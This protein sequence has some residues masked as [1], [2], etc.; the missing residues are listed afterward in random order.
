M[1]TA[2]L[3]QPSILRVTQIG[4][5]VLLL[6]VLVMPSTNV[7]ARP[8][9]QTAPLVYQQSAQATDDV[10]ITRAQDSSVIGD[11]IW[12]YN[13]NGG[14]G[15]TTVNDP[16]AD[17]ILSPVTPEP[18]IG[19]GAF[20]YSYTLKTPNETR[21]V[22]KVKVSWEV[23]DPQNPTL[24]VASGMGAYQP[25]WTNAFRVTLPNA[26]G[27]YTLTVRFAVLFEGFPRNY[28]QMLSNQH[29]LYVLLHQPVHA[30]YSEERPYWSWTT[31]TPNTTW[32]EYATTWA[33]GAQSD[34]AV[35]AALN[36]KIYSNPLNWRYSGSSSGQALLSGSASN[37]NCFSIADA[38]HILAGTHG[39][40]VSRAVY[41]PIFLGP[42]VSERA[43][44]S[45]RPVENLDG[46]AR[47]TQ[48]GQRD[49]WLTGEHSFLV[50]GGR[51][52]EPTFGTSGTYVADNPDLGFGENV[53][54]YITSD[55]SCV[56]GNTLRATVSVSQPPYRF[57][58]NLWIIEDYTLR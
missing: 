16:I 19:S 9:Q 56:K 2:R 31:E 48:T 26:V 27:K 25:G 29:T 22:P 42:T 32:L 3:N 53:Y 14:H 39:I 46:N 36:A 44:L 17:A 7:S 5:V 30:Q 34:A 24:I 55:G 23:R 28:P 10:T 4:M 35:L 58:T 38:L 21:A 45:G 20:T 13:Y 12:Q 51:Y 47:N 40:P 50:Y 11:V 8:S 52:Y 41:K 37:G 6:A 54:C 1:H 49:R 43:P 15:Y 33:A 57:N 18:S